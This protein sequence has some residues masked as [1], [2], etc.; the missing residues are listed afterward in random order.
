MS[1]GKF[2]VVVGGAGVVGLAVARAFAR[3]G[4][5]CL[6]IEREVNYKILFL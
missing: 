3:K 4:F 6:V 2:Q 5:E 1:L